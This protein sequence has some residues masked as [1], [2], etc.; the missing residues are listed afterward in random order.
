LAKIFHFERSTSNER[1]IDFRES[2]NLGDIGEIHASAI[3]ERARE[4]RF[5]GG[6]GLLDLL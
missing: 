5:E 2:E 4:M 3:K 1:A 6:V